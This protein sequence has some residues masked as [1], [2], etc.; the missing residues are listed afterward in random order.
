MRTGY[1]AF[2]VRRVVHFVWIYILLVYIFSLLLNTQV[3]LLERRSLETDL[4][5]QMLDQR[6]QMGLSPEEFERAFQEELQSVI[7]E[8][9]YDKPFLA[10]SNQYALRIL[11]FDFG[12][13]LQSHPVYFRGGVNVI[14]ILG[15]FVAPTLAV[16]T[17]AFLA[18]ML[19]GV[20]LGMRNA[21]RHGS[22]LDRATSILAGLSM[23]IPPAVAAMFVM[24]ALAIAVPLIPTNTWIFWFPKRWAD[25]GPWAAGFFSHAAAPFL[26]VVFLSMWQTAHT[27]RNIVLPTLQEDFITAGRGRGLPEHRVLYRLGLRTSAPPLATLLILGLT[28][29]LWGS[30]LVEPIFQWRGIGTLLLWA[31]VANEI[32][33]LMALLVIFTLVSLFGQLALDVA[34]GWLDPRIRVSGRA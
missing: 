17:T 8:R 23:S 31:I 19:I 10:R 7:H 25:A 27:V 4:R 29:T 2:V 20:L 12:T 21:S 13:T 11:R 34:Y 15:E 1:S 5:G 30:F 16:F 18:Q 6:G 9:G 14:S 28:T 24:L 33:I 3:E 32:N 26:T 22:F